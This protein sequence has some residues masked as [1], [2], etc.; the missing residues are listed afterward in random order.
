[1]ATHIAR[2]RI[3]RGQSCQS[4][5]WSAEQGKWIFPCPRSHLRVWSCET[6][7]AVASRVSLLVSIL[8]VN[9][10]LTAFFPS[11]AAASIYLLSRPPYAI[12]SVPSSYRVTLLRTG[13]VHCRESVGTGS[14]HLKVVPNECYLV[15]SPW[16]N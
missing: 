7:S 16:T 2:V 14:V 4:C 12:G 10:V 9:L 11:F 6:V 3:K 15:R 5:S 13:G 8:K 1:M